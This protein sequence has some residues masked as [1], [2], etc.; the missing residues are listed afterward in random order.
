MARMT[1]DKLKAL[2]ELISRNPGEALALLRAYRQEYAEDQDLRWNSGGFLTDIGTAL[3]DSKLVQEAIDTIK[4][5][6][7]RAEEE[8]VPTLIYNLGNAYYALH[9]VAQC[10]PGFSYCP[11]TTPLVH[12]KACYRKALRATELPDLLLRVQLLI[13]Y[14]NCL[15]NLCRPV[16]AILQYRAA[17]ELSPDYPMAQGNLGIELEHF[18][19]IAPYKRH[20][21]DAQ[22]VLSEALEGA[23][24]EACAPYGTRQRFEDAL[25][26][27][28]KWLALPDE[29]IGDEAPAKPMRFASEHHKSYSEFCQKHQLFLNFYL[30]TEL[31]EHTARDT[32]ALSLITP[33]G[34]NTTFPRLARVVDEAKERYA[35]ARLHV[36]EARDPAADLLPYEEMTDYVDNIDYAVRG[37]RVAKLKSAFEAAYNVLDKI[38]FFV[39]DY[40][41]L[42]IRERSTSF[43]TIWRRRKN[44]HLRPEILDRRNLYLYGLYDIAR[45]LSPDGFLSALRT[46][47]NC[48]TH[49]YIVP[50]VMGDAEGDVWLACADGAQYHIGYGELLERSL[51]LLSLVRSAII[52]LIAFIDLE[53]RRKL[54]GSDGPIPQMPV[55]RY[56]HS[57]LGPQD[58]S[59]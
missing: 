32:L 52:Y 2:S 42:G 5:E 24:L 4:A 20:I 55:Q 48:A 11:D 19:S 38:A 44:G 25:Q 26:R 36:Y 46:I 14:G 15:S 37:L 35:L 27:V 18:A 58:S 31:C 57:P 23:R 21:L 54:A 34:D 16:E 30:S 45:D 6:L 51:E 56:T 40:L 22:T 47:R 17:L 49:R 33:V 50:H 1:P 59:T 8:G 9:F 12:A 39:N 10:Q 53:Q 3:Q 13:N 7:A 41:R 43:D 28:Q 29:P